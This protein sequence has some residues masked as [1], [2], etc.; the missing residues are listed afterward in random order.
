M[1]QTPTAPT[2]RVSQSAYIR[3]M[4]AVMAECAN[5]ED[6]H[7]IILIEAV[8]SYMNDSKLRPVDMVLRNT[9]AK[10]AAMIDAAA[11]RSAKAR[12]A[13]LNRRTAKPTAKPEIET[14]TETESK[15][16]S[17]KSEPKPETSVPAINN[18]K[19]TKTP[20][21]S[22]T[23]TQHPRLRIKIKHKHHNKR[24]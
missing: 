10:F 15:Q 24:K 13:A 14:T 7:A 1:K 11:T 16:S 5:H 17:A 6:H 23:P 20:K 4:N 2:L 3:I 8:N 18:P 12:Q 21:P 19:T 22:P 9:L